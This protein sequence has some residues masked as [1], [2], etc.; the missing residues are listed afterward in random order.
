ME[1]CQA[2]WWPAAK[3]RKCGSSFWPQYTKQ[4]TW[5][6][7]TGMG[8]LA[9]ETA[10]FFPWVLHGSKNLEASILVRELPGV[11]VTVHYSCL[12]GE[13]VTLHVY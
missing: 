13:L 2:R 12:V 1:T 5:G 11:E 4:E 9:A 6:A 3:S 10:V 8:T 7:I